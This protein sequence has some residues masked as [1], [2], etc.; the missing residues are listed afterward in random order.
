MAVLKTQ[1]TKA[2][3]PAFLAAVESEE[4]RK[5]SKTLLKLFT[6]IT[7]E[8]PAL[9][10]TAIVGFGTYSYKSERSKQAGDWFMVGFSPRKA[11]IAVY[12]IAGI[13][14]YQALLK[15]LGKFKVSTGSCL[16]IN[17]L[18]DIDLDVL[19]E[20]ISSGYQEMHSKHG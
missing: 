12:V 2:S 3:V 6:D 5:D 16:Y 17:K 8:K 19:K 20:I 9:W 13:N 1:K 15:K 11:Y 14:K 4:K 10:G 7:K 18:A